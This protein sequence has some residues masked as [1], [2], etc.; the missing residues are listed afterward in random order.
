MSVCMGMRVRAHICICMNACFKVSF[1]VK[2]H[3]LILVSFLAM[4]EAKYAQAQAT[5]AVA[6]TQASK[7][8]ADLLL[9]RQEVLAARECISDLQARLDASA[10]KLDDTTRALRHAIA[11]EAATTEKWR[12]LQSQ[13]DARKYETDATA[14]TV[15]VC[16][17]VF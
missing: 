12:A 13:L 3:K 1:G 16:C 8:N 5:A 6:E 10:A 17:D 2:I 9:T 7:T 14:M 15:K 11:E 4:Q